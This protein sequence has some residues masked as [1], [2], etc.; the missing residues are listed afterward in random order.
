MPLRCDLHLHTIDDPR[1]AH[2]RHTASELFTKAHSLAFNALAITLHG[3]QVFYSAWEDE[4]ASLGITLI[5]GVEQDIDGCHVLLLGFPAEA[6][7]A[8]HNFRQLEALRPLGGLVIAAHPFFPGEICLGEKLIEHI[9]LFD[10][11][12]VTS[13]WHHRWNP[14]QKA[15]E[16]AQKFGKPV[17]GN[18]DTHTLDQFGLTYS[19]VSLSVQAPHASSPAV[20]QENLTQDI[21]ESIRAG[22]VNAITRPLNTWEM[23][24]IGAKVVAR[25]YLP[26]VDDKRSRKYLPPM[27]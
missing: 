16:V 12:E 7:N 1:D 3:E 20:Q 10:A 24:K 5:P 9:E 15:R 4:A 18:S 6:A 27:K 8:V 19:E 13:F 2:V 17:I 22:R 14:N 11:I 25:S 23:S 26:W 21:L